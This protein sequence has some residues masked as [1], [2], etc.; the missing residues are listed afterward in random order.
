M[1]NNSP[2]F[3]KMQQDHANLINLE[4]IRHIFAYFSTIMFAY[5]RKF[6]LLIIHTK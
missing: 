5:D 4:M 6:L 3:K 1:N 2:F